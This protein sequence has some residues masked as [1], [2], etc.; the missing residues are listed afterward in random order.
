M[1]RLLARGPV[2]VHFLDF[3]Q[4]NS[5]RSL[6][7]VVAWHERYRNAGLAVLGVH[8]PRSPLTADSDALAR[9]LV[10]LSVAHPVAADLGYAIWHDY[11]CDGWPS[12]FLWGHG[13]TLRWF[14]FGEGAYRG[15]ELAIQEELRGAGVDSLPPPLEPLRPTDAP[16]AVVIAP[17][18][19]LLPGGSLEEPWRASDASSSLSVEYEAGGAFAS[20]NG[21]GRLEV[22]VDAGPPRTIGIDG[23]ALYELAAHPHHERHALRIEASPAVGVWSIS[24]APGVPPPG[25]AR[26]P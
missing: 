9:A 19:E 1:E 3:A 18:P 5:V 11:G 8:S 6:P 16:D 7:Y 22:T 25:R 13:G 2:L 4:L 20:A 23:P 12:L 15:T 10:R 21:E 14:H 26:P 24:F 17:T